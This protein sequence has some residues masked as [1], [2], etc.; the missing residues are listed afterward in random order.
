MV[1]RSPLAAALAGAGRA[2]RRTP[3]Q[4]KEKGQRRPRLRASAPVQEE[5][6][7]A[8]LLR[9]G[10]GAAAARLLGKSG[11]KVPRVGFSLWT[12]EAHRGKARA[13]AVACGLGR[14]N[15]PP[16]HLVPK[17]SSAMACRAP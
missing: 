5:E 3:Q 9:E 15:G 10:S 6:A 8:R 17:A 7:Q 11:E 2:W 12:R 4:S 14:D 16:S 1:F 13:W